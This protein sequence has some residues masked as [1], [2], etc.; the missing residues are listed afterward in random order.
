MSGS[1]ATRRRSGLAAAGLLLAVVLGLGYAATRLGTAG[2]APPQHA[3]PPRAAITG[4]IT[5]RGNE[6]VQDGRPLVIRGLAMIGLMSPPAHLRWKMVRAYSKLDQAEL[7]EAKRYGANTIRYIISLG[8][9]LKR[10]VTW[11]D[12]GYL[13]EIRNA[14]RTTRRLG[15]NVI[16]TLNTEKPGDIFHCPLP[17]RAVVD[18]WKVLAR[19]FGHE[20]N[21]MFELYNEP[22]G[23]PTAANWHLW[24]RGGRLKFRKGNHTCRAVG[25]QSLVRSIREDHSENVLIAPG[26]LHQDT[27]AG[28][29]L[30]ADPG[31]GN[32]IAYG[33]HLQQYGGPAQWNHEFGRIAERVPVIVTEWNPS[34]ISMHCTA[35]D[36]YDTPRASAQLLRYLSA[37][38]I[39]LVG[40][41]FDS[42]GTL[43]LGYGKRL[44]TYHD[45]ACGQPD[46]GP[47]RLLHRYFEGKLPERR[48]AATRP[49]ATTTP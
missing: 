2:A 36:I 4:P 6:L 17:N 39:G 49:A 5:V 21:V 11:Y 15:M 42:P 8:G 18:V 38:G 43:R 32:E 23:P 7:V 48:R 28:V 10:R 47:G 33:I 16:L 29:P 26:L 37:R 45:F 40:Y 19:S 3:A 22:T 12:P 46:S 9:L 41:A 13:T 44:T 14:V 20:R 24:L 25:M 27:L 1:G 34:S 35:N 30:L 31:R